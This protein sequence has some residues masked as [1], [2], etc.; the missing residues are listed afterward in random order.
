MERIWLKSYPPGVPHEIDESKYRSVVELLTESFQAFRDRK[1]FICMDRALTYG[2]LGEHSQAFAA[3]LQSTGLSPG[4]R[5]AVMLPN[6]L[7]YPVALAGI[8][9]AGYV[10]VN[11]NP[12]YTARELEFQ[13]KDSGAEA[14]IVLENFASVVQQVVARTSVK[15][16]VVATMGD[17][18]GLVKGTIVNL[19]VRNIKKLVPAYSLPEATTFNAA[20][21]A[22]RNMTLHRPKIEPDDVA[23][24]QYTGG[25]TGVA[26]GATLL[27][28]NIVANIL[29]ADAWLQP[30]LWREP[31]VGQLF[32]V[33]ALPLYHIFAL[34]A[35]ALLGMRA[36]AVCLLI[37]NPRDIKGLIGELRKY[38]VNYFPAV[39]TLFNGLLN[40]PDFG[41]IDWR[42]LRLTLGGGMAVQKTTAERWL[43]ATG[44]PIVEAYGLSE[45]SPGLTSN[46]SD[47]HVYSGA[48][49]LPFPSTE[50][51]IRDENDREVPLGQAGEIC[52]RGPQV[53]AG[54]WQRPDETALVM[55]PDGFFRTGDIGVMSLDGSISIV[56]RKKDMI[57][58]SGFKVFPNEV[59]GVVA[60]HPGVLECAVIGVPDDKTGE[61]VKLFVVRK[62]PS[63]T[64]EE[65]IKYCHTQLTSYKVPKQVEFHNE[66]PKSNVG[67]ILRRALRDQPQGLSAA[68]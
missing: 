57:T 65:L 22:G 7:Q 35:C 59:E 29:Q 48:I 61:A 55:T 50:I 25:T 9:R 3:W 34:T 40:H 43:K 42:H 26:K 30:A 10:V 56:D 45:T 47:S 17:L 2:Q 1:A 16:V 38:P 53:M 39:N 8:L 19:V 67:K 46:R 32:L 37:P 11:F 18:L 62:D 14:I 49:G 4:A 5:V 36:G 12:L 21:A 66:L 31:K 64:A 33:A 58:V 44:Q 54:Y 24:L 13:L 15:H 6:V 63:L 51:S 20:L 52:A 27:H 41:R 68:A 28:R 23:F 60:A